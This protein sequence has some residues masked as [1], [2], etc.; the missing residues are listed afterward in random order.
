MKDKLRTSRRL[1][2]FL[3][4]MPFNKPA[5]GTTSQSIS[6]SARFSSVFINHSP[7]YTGRTC[8]QG[9]PGGSG[10]KTKGTVRIKS[11]RVRQFNDGLF[12]RGLM[13]WLTTYF[14]TDQQNFM[15]RMSMIIR[16]SIFIIDTPG[17]L[18]YSSGVNGVTA[19]LNINP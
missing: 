15:D 1:E 16:L 6:I 19:A 17:R 10:I 2:L 3:C 5:A 12:F 18:A 4:F 11:K 14:Y 9:Y 8:R 13:P 7:L